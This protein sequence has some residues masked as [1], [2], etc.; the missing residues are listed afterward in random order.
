MCLNSNRLN[1]RKLDF[2]KKKRCI[3][4]LQKDSTVSIWEFYSG[5]LFGGGK[6]CPFTQNAN[7]ERDLVGKITHI[8][9]LYA[10]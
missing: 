8:K 1:N 3:Q 2:L 5:L 6:G 9:T 10:N 7:E 4:L